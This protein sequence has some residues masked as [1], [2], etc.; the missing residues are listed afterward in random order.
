MPC[1][2]PADAELTSCNVHATSA[3]KCLHIT[4]CVCTATRSNYTQSAGH[5]YSKQSIGRV[6]RQTDA[7][8]LTAKK[9]QW[10]LPLSGDTSPTHSPICRVHHN[11]S[12]YRLPSAVHA[13]ASAAYNRAATLL[14]PAKNRSLYG[15][16]GLTA[17]SAGASAGQSGL[18]CS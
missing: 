13:D 10:P 5:L 2:E 8:S 14:M 18:R 17:S 16:T 12:F 11:K 9:K 6:W 15:S 7:T 4:A 3:W 1:Q